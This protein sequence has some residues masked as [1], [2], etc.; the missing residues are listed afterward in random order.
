MVRPKE[1]E[2]KHQFSVMLKPS[3]VDEIDK[4]ADKYNLTRSQLMAN[5]MEAGLDEM[6]TLDKIG[7][8]PLIYH[9]TNIMKKFKE[10][11]FKGKVSLDEKGDIK[12]NK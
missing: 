2:P 1:K 3:V 6:R 11:L 10:A 9:G 5:M 12:I 8:I 4:F 7:V